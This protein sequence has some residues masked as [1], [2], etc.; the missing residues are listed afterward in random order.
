MDGAL[1]PQRPVHRAQREVRAG[2]HRVAN[3]TYRV[4]H[5]GYG[6]SA[7]PLGGQGDFAEP[8]TGYDHL[9][10]GVSFTF[11]LALTSATNFSVS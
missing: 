10:C 1:L 9:G 7:F 4:A 6:A 2:G 3:P 11:M 5:H 8:G